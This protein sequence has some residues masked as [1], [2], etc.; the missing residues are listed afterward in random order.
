MGPLKLNNFDRS[1]TEISDYYENIDDLNFALEVVAKDLKGYVEKQS[2]KGGSI[3]NLLVY[4]LGH[5]CRVDGKDCLL[6]VDGY[7]STPCWST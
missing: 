2:R 5:G 7:P 1:K 4:F 6:G 3:G